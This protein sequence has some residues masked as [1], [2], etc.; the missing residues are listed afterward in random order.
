MKITP[1][2]I[3]GAAIVAAARLVSA[4]AIPTPEHAT[5]QVV[6]GVAGSAGVYRAQD[7]P[8]RG[9]NCGDVLDALQSDTEFRGEI[10]QVYSTRGSSGECYN[11]HGA[12]TRTAVVCCDTPAG[13]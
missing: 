6:T 2:L 8:M 13:S 10:R 1:F 7:Y 3:A 12:S 5:T 9:R 11:L 4:A